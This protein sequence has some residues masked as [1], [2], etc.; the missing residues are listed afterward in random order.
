[1]QKEYEEKMA[2]QAEEFGMN[3][4]QFEEQRDQMLAF[5]KQNEEKMAKVL[6]A[7]EKLN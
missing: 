5:Q 4:K 2:K 6:E 1:M 7:N 3:V